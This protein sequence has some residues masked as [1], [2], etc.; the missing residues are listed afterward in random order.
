MPLRAVKAFSEGLS[1]FLA[2]TGVMSAF[3]AWW[4]HA[5]VA[6][7]AGA[8]GAVFQARY[9]RNVTRPHRAFEE[10]FGADWQIRLAK[11]IPAQQRAA[12]L[13]QRWSWRMPRSTNQPVWDRNMV[14]HI[15]P[16]EMGAPDIHLECDLWLPPERIPPTG[17]SILYVHG[18][19]Y[20][21][22]QKDF[23]TRPFFR[24]LVSQ[25]HAVMDINYRLGDHASL[26][27]MLSDVM[28][29]VA[30]LK[31][32]SAL[33][34]VD[35]NRIVLAG[36]SAGAHLAL[37]AAYA[38]D[39]PGL[40]PADLAGRDLSVHAVVSYY[41][42][43]DLLAAYQRLQKLFSTA[44]RQPI[45]GNS[46]LARK[47]RLS[48]KRLPALRRLPVLRRPPALRRPLPRKLL[49]P[50]RLLERRVFRRAVAAAAWM[51]GVEPEA[52]K[53]YLLQNQA[54]LSNGLEQAFQHLLGCSP[55]AASEL[56]ELVSPLAYARPGCPPTLLF[57]GAHD[58]LLPTSVTHSLHHRLRAAGVPSVYVEL[59]QTE[60]TFDQFLPEWSPP[61]QVALYD[62]D[63]F[64]ALIG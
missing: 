52:F 35:P 16:G 64:L 8:V 63:R 29:A 26:F 45:S 7:L 46:T 3:G 31:E 36:G 18:G 51:R 57:Q 5:P 14:Y 62:L 12:L 37:L 49:P 20:Y 54:A 13:Q 34:G 2:I 39:N 27:D 40:V 58:Y 44:K 47:H 56:F 42:V 33:F 55:E 50:D 28:H 1:P 60:H 61:A 22:T 41:G 43:I 11:K 23:G 32:N 9:I 48:L 19:G 4:T 15:I 10:P 24:H 30:W 59:P 6:A 53:A 21:T 17:L 25:G 38:H